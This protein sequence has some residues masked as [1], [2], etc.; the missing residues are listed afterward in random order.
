MGN[1]DET[2]DC[3]VSLCILE[4]IVVGKLGIGTHHLESMEYKTEIQL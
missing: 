3:I 2:G 4:A 1:I